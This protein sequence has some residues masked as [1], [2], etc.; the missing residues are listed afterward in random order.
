MIA[1]FFKKSKPINFVIVL[2]LMLLVFVYAN[3]TFIKQALGLAFIGKQLVVFGISIF[4]VFLLNFIVVKNKLAEPTGY[5]ILIYVLFMGLFP[6]A[7]VCT[8]TLLA[9]MFILLALRRIISMKSKVHLSKKLFDA[10]FWIGIAT[11]FY[12][13]SI[14]FFLLIFIALFLFSDNQIK[15]W[16]IPFTGIATVFILLITYHLV[17]YNSLEVL[18][19]H[20]PIFNFDFSVY[21]TSKQVASIT[22]MFSFGLWSTLFYIKSL[23][24]KSKASKPLHKIIVGATVLAIIIAI[25]SKIKDSGEFVFMFALLAIN[26]SNY[27][28]TIE[29]HWFKEVFLSIFVLAPIVLLVL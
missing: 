3:L 24:G 12:F 28:E 23:K 2:V 4:T 18:Y 19:S 13:W 29:E 1:S 8:K 15:H 21:N 5:H 27:I 22:L 9:N 7:I 14:L 25:L 6:F 17:A 20:F 10:A 11:L 26:I 16:L